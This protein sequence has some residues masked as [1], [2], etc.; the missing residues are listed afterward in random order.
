MTKPVDTETLVIGAGFAG[1]SVAERLVGRDVTIVDRGEPFDPSAARLRLVEP[2]WNHQFGEF[3]PGV[4]AEARAMI[5]ERSEHR[6]SLPLS[7]MT[8]NVYSYRQGG[9][10]NWWGG[11]AKRVTDACF[12]QDGVL[13]WP[14]GLDVLQP[15]YRQAE[16]LLRVHGDP[17]RADATVYAAM[18]GWDHWRNYL[19]PLFPGAHVTSEAKNVSD[20]SGETTMGYCTGNG[21]CALCGN[22]AK[23]RPATVFPGPSVAS[24]TMVRSLVFDGSRA[25][26]AHCTTDGEDYDVRFERVVLA[27]GGLE[28]TALLRRSRLPKA[29]RRELIGRWYQDHTAAEIMVRMPDPV[30]FFQIGA[31]AHVELPDLSGMYRGLEVKALF[32]TIPADAVIM[33]QKI[34]QG[35][36]A[37]AANLRSARDRIG[38]IYLQIEVPPEWDMRIRTRGEAAYLYTMPYFQKLPLLDLVTHEVMAKLVKKGLRIERVQPYYRS[39]F[40]GHHYS[41]VTPMSRNDNALV[42]SDHLLL[43]S[44]NVYVSGASV[45]PR[46]GS[47]GP[48]LSIV[49]M[50]LRLGDILQASD[51]SVHGYNSKCTE[52]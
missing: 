16:H 51:P 43:G 41:G 18:P 33:N 37:D 28:N 7:I 45:M 40:G 32:L 2:S 50:G 52:S 13:A 6:V 9:I 46:C 27:A 23:A 1:L 20:R 48:T 30:P 3:G 24:R 22:D 25:V 26:A 14:I 49:A 42:S 36:L 44:D 31:E 11:Y 15:Y 4:E 34:C 8:A 47:A 39:A 10:S 5:S 19:A 21:H 35:T 17:Q 29:V 12:Q 38:R